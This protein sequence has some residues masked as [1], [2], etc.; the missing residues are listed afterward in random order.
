MDRIWFRYKTFETEPDDH[1]SV[2]DVL[3]FITEALGAEDIA[4]SA[5]LFLLEDDQIL[6]W[7]MSELEMN[8]MSGSASHQPPKKKRRLPGFRKLT[9]KLA[10]ISDLSVYNK[11]AEEAYKQD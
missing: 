1:C 9:R 5:D 8:L 4:T 10:D 6:V 11:R 2:D 3:A 7:Q